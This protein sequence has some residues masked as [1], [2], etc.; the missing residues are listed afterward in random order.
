MLA[1]S[2][3]VFL[4]R[5]D[6]EKVGTGYPRGGCLLNGKKKN[7]FFSLF[8]RSQMKREHPLNLSILL[9]GGKETNK[10]SLSNGE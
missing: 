4:R 9:R 3:A 10:D 5:R 6:L 2:L 1:S 8:I 7:F